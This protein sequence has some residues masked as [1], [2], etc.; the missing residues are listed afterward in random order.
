MSVVKVGE[1]KYVIGSAK[2]KA[3][4]FFELNEQNKI[5]NINKIEV[6][7]RVR[8]I[9]LKKNKLYLFLENTASIGVI[10]LN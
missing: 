1:K 7:E 10:N 5:V 6:Y 4:Y 2:T 3:L 9:K 8:D